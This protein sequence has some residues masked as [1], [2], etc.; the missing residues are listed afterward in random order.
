MY[1]HTQLYTLGCN[2]SY[3]FRPNRRSIFRLIS[4]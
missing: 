2:S 3:M 4:E 1:S